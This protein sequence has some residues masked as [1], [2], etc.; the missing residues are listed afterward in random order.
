MA[1]ETLGRVDWEHGGEPVQ[2]KRAVVTGGTTGIGRAIALI[3]AANGARVLVFGRD[4]QDLDD[5]LKDLRS[6]AAD[7]GAVHGMTADASK[8]EDI[9]RVFEQADQ[10][11]GGVDILVN[12]AAL[13]ARSV[14]DME[15]A[16]IESVV[17]TNVLGYMHCARLALERMIPAGRGQ[18]V[19]IGS[20]SA[21]VKEK[22]SDVYVATKTAIAGFCD[23]LRKQVNEKG[24][25]VTL[26]EPGRVGSNLSSDHPDAG[27]QR[28]R[29][30]ADEMLTAED[31]AECVFFCLTQPWRCEIVNVEIRPHKQII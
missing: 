18:I 10:A 8:P 23:A 30:D 11:L 25:K 7:G 19:C 22:G 27:K 2:G 4:Q 24:V 28:Q 13:A 17:R 20:M 1:A 29:I 31:I 21:D 12:N 9:Q 26:V 14:T 6:V 16:A 5:A 15:P 3:L